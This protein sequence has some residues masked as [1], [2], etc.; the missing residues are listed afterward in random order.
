MQNSYS[1]F[2]WRWHA[3]LAPLVDDGLVAVKQD[4]ER[5]RH[6]GGVRWAGAGL[7]EGQGD[8]RPVGVVLAEA[9]TGWR[10][11]APHPTLPRF[12]GV[13]NAND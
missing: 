2:L 12:A 1:T 11:F 5:L 8:V 4:G 6:S 9:V 13:Q 7:P 3:P 10:L